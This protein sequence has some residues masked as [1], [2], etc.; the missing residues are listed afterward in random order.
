MASRQ[1]SKAEAALPAPSPVAP[2]SGTVLGDMTTTLRWSLPQGTVQVHIEVLPTNNDGA[3]ID[4][5]TYKT[6]SFTI[7]G[8]PQYYMLLPDMTYTWRVRA[9]DGL[10]VPASDRSWSGWSV[11]WTFRTPKATSGGIQALSPANGTTLGSLSPLFIQWSDPNPRIF[12]YEVQVSGDS[13]F[14]TN[15]AMGKSFVW[16]NIVHG[17][18]GGGTP[19]NSWRTPPLDSGRVYYWR[20]RPRVQGDGTPVAWSSTFNFQ[21]PVVSP[22]PTPTP[23]PIPTPTPAPVDNLT[24]VT[25]YFSSGG[26]NPI[27]GCVDPSYRTT[28]V[29]QRDLTPFVVWAGQG[30]IELR[31]FRDGVPHTPGSGKYRAPSSESGCSPVYFYAEYFYRYFF[32]PGVYEVDVLNKGVLIQVIV[33]LVVP[34]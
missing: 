4:L 17:N 13:K 22:T 9:S 33:L 28:V 29:K 2:A 19:P 3:G 23:P 34:D 30:V 15:P 32:P 5:I 25:V 14:D 11:P 26:L 10:G 27:Y 31:W 12:Y 16:W 8:P 18:V 21:A 20:V 24:K 7:P 1:P 6:E